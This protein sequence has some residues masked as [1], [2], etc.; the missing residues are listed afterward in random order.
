MGSTAQNFRPLCVAKPFRHMINRRATNLSL[1][2][3]HN[4]PFF[5]LLLAKLLSE[6]EGVEITLVH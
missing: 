4:H 5:I 2:W 6:Q 3:L 1:L